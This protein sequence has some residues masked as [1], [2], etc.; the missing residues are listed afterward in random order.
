MGRGHVSLLARLDTWHS[1]TVRRIRQVMET[2]R[3]L[4]AKNAELVEAGARDDSS[5]PIRAQ[6]NLEQFS[7][8]LHGV[9][10]LGPGL[11]CSKLSSARRLEAPLRAG[12]GGGRG[13]GAA[14]QGARAAL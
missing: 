2:N 3:A 9:E 6:V 11:N 8:F 14:H 7:T 5:S 10:S 12:A 4:A 1:K 13:P